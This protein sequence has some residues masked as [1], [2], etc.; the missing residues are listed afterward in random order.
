[1]ADLYYVSEFDNGWD[2]KEYDVSGSSATFNGTVS[3]IS[4]PIIS[5]DKDGSGNYYGVTRDSDDVVKWDSNF[6]EVWRTGISNGSSRFDSGVGGFTVGNGH[7]VSCSII[8]GDLTYAILD[9]SSGSLI[10]ESSDFMNPISAPLHANFTNDRW[11]V[12][13]IDND[14]Q[15]SVAEFDYA[16]NRISLNNS[17]VNLENNNDTDFQVRITH[18]PTGGVIV[19][20][21]YTGTGSFLAEIGF[22]AVAFDDTLSQVGSYT[23]TTSSTTLTENFAAESDGT[24]VFCW[25]ELKIYKF[26]KD[27]NLV[28]SNN[29]ISGF[30]RG[31]HELT[32]N[33]YYAGGQR[34]IYKLD[35]STNLIWEDSASGNYHV[36]GTFPDYGD[37]PSAFATSEEITSSQV[38]T[39]ADMFTASAIVPTEFISASPFVSG[40]TMNGTAPAFSVSLL[41]TPTVSTASP[42]AGSVSMSQPSEQFTA[43]ALPSDGTISAIDVSA[44]QYALSAFMLSPDVSG[45]ISFNATQTTV[46]APQNDGAIT[47]AN[48]GATQTS[49]PVTMGVPV[50]TTE[51]ISVQ[52]SAVASVNTSGDSLT[53]LLGASQISARGREFNASTILNPFI[54]ATSISVRSNSFSATVGVQ[55]I[56]RFGD[57]T[58]AQ[59]VGTENSAEI[60]ATVNEVE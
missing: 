17:F 57:M 48:L 5:L 22:A 9:S 56:R 10:T 38:S 59:I 41:A 58:D 32:P 15:I 6:N 26:D 37:F 60:E 19:S 29:A 8:S 11:F 23:E 43:S 2:L 7:V 36:G 45:L 49:A 31:N 4:E 24:N 34:D 52:P 40:A 50:L 46:S 33:N 44:S 13:Y 21:V 54:D 47:A 39:T 27:L 25:D 30:P 18:R 1:M 35:K 3:G 53:T 55:V 14:G 12:G 51:I 20:N 28:T 16:G 42:S